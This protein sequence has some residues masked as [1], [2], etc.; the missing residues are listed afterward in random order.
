MPLK[1]L[2]AGCLVLLALILRQ[3]WVRR[4]ADRRMHRSPRLDIGLPTDGTEPQT[5]RAAEDD[6]YRAR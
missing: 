6:T 5:K 1:L 3:A 4:A 2:L